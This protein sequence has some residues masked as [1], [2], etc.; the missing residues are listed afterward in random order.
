MS[1]IAQTIRDGRTS[2]LA[3]VKGAP[4]VLHPMIRDRCPKD[5]DK[6]YRRLAREGYRVLALGYKL[7]KVNS[8][9][10]AS[11]STR[12]MI[13]CDLIFAGLL[14][15]NCPLKEDSREAILDLK[16]SSHFVSFLLNSEYL[17]MKTGVSEIH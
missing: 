5:F 7:L 11:Q 1:V 10:Q 8:L 3:T 6:L 16:N 17:L 4:E 14:V 12:E 13:E 15:F 2:Y 9:H